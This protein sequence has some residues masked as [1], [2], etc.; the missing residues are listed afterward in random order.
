MVKRLENK[1]ALVTGGSSGIG[2]STAFAFAREGATVVVSSRSN[3]KSGTQIARTIE[4]RGGKARFVQA[5]VANSL[6]VQNLVNE[7]IATYG[8]LDIGFNNAG[9]QGPAAVYT[10]DSTESDWDRVI[11]LNLTGTFLCMKYELKQ[12]LEQGGGTIVNTA[13]ISALNGT[14]GCSS[15]VASKHAVI[16]LTKSAALDYASRGIRINAICPGFTKTPLLE[17]FVDLS[18]AAA[19][20]RI[21]DRIPLGRIANPDNIADVVV[22]LCSDAASYITAHAL[23]IDGGFTAQL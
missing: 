10:A 20:K 12:M 23:T 3:V 13:S 16:G 1:V 17:A 19:E 15:Y 8:R 5:D 2:E 9:T 4:E 7:T 14:R 18:D 11:D 6:D 21:A 22:W